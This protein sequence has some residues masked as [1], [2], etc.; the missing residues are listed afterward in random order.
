MR[1]ARIQGF[2]VR[3]IS[4]GKPEKKEELIVAQLV[5]KF[6]HLFNQKVHYVFTRMC[7]GSCL[8]ADKCSPH[9]YIRF[10]LTLIL[11][12][13]LQLCFP[14]GLLPS[15]FPAYISPTRATCPACFTLLD[16][17]TVIILG[18]VYKLKVLI[19][20]FPP[21]FY[22]FSILCP[23]VLFNTLFSTPSVC[24]LTPM[25]KKYHSHTKQGKL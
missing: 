21:S 5:K 18:E 13:H 23:S 11:P 17:F 25:W 14:S 20:L 24:V 19:V 9:I 7:P 6:L 8:E 16:L 4:A 15:G 12:S 1:I 3:K 2:N 22:Y 10:M